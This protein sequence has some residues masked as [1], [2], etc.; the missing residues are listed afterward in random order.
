MEYEEIVE[1]LAPCGLDCSRCIYYG[2]G[3]INGAATELRVALEGFEKVAPMV[4]KTMAPVLEEYDTFRRILD[5]FADGDCKGCRVDGPPLPFCAARTCF[6]DKG[7]DFCFQCDEFPCDHN[8]FPDSIDR[9]WRD[10]N[11]RMKEIG[12]EAFHEESLR[13]P[14][15]E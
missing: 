6:R 11:Q 5:L 8:T 9:R 2:D 10:Y 7:V 13:R 3:A 1:R 15:Y 4:A 14:R 12:V